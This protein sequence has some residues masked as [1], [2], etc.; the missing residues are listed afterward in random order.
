M[1]S[2]PCLTSPQREQ[3]RPLLVLRD[4]AYLRPAG[5]SHDSHHSGTRSH[6]SILVVLR[7]AGISHDSHHSLVFW[8]FDC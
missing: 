6:T 2:K 1:K 4:K 7:P 5:I 3:G 8:T